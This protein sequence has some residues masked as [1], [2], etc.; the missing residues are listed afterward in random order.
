MRLVGVQRVRVGRVIAS[1]SYVRFVVLSHLRVMRRFSGSVNVRVTSA[2]GRVHSRAVPD[3]KFGVVSSAPETQ[4]ALGNFCR[5]LRVTTGLDLAPAVYKSY[6]E[7]LKSTVDGI[8]DVV[9]APP[10]IAIELED[11]GIAM[12]A[13]VVRRSSRV[14]YYSA[15]FCLADAPFQRV[16]EL[17]KVRAAW[18]TKESA[19]GYVVPRWHLRSLGVRLADAFATEEFFAS[20]EAMTQAVLDNRADVGSTHVSLDPV[21]GK[22]ASAPWLALGAAPGAVRVLLLVGPIPG[23]VVAI[24]ARVDSGARRRLIAALVALRDDVDGLALFEAGAF[25]PVPDG[26]LTLLRRLAR[27]NETRA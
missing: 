4:E 21:T 19:S 26:H 27:F 14:G 22:L 2:S 9:W 15:L 12:P 6:G 11:R 5:R 16:E 24:S 10:L 1:E 13:V 23:D 25:E 18:V 7:L 3:V 20:H 8:V 17:S